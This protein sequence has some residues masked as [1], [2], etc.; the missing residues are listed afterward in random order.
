MLD[1][2]KAARSTTACLTF[3]AAALG[4]AAAG[5]AA[6]QTVVQEVTVTAR[7]PETKATSLAYPVSYRD[8]DLRTKDGSDE[9]SRRIEMTAD[10]LCKRLGEKEKEPSSAYLPSCRADAVGRAKAAAKAAHD[11]AVASAGTWTPGPAWIPPGGAG[12]R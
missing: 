4:L 11:Q 5:P 3:V 7:I 8:L 1:G 2:R 9:L 6:G 10:Y 12:P